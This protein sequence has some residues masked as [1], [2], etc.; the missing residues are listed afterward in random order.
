MKG[1]SHVT[2]CSSLPTYPFLVP[3]CLVAFYGS[4]SGE[5]KYEKIYIY[6]ILAIG[7]EIKE[8][9]IFTVVTFY[10]FLFFV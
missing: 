10:W 5:K 4:I 1:T 2:S 9:Q 8:K 3:K 7:L 6:L